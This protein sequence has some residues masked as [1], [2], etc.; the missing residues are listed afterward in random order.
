[1]PDSSLETPHDSFRP[2]ALAVILVAF[3]ISRMAALDAGVFIHVRADFIQLVDFPLLSSHLLQSIF[4][5]HS[6][7]PLLNLLLGIALKLFPKDYPIFFAFLFWLIGLFLALTLYNLM[8]ALGVPW[9]LS[10][11]LTLLFEIGPATILFE[12]LYYE[13]YPVAL[14]L[15][16]AAYSL[17]RFLRT[18]SRFHG[19]IFV[20]AL[21]LP[22][23]LNAS[24][25]VTWFLGIGAILFFLADARIKTLLPAG[26]AMLAVILALYVK[27]LIVFGTFTTSSSFG[28]A[29]TELTTRQLRA[30]EINDLVKRHILSSYALMLPFPE[31]SP[32]APPTG[33]PVLDETV[34]SRD[35]ASRPNS[36]SIEYLELTRADVHDALW[37]IV[38][39]PGAFARGEWRGIKNY[40]DPASINLNYLQREKIERWSELYEDFLYP[41]GLPTFAVDSLLDTQ[42]RTAPATGPPSTVLMIALPALVLFGIIK[43]FNSWKATHLRDADGVTMLYIVLAILYTTP[44]GALVTLNENNRYRYVLDPLYVVL[45]GLLITQIRT[46]VAGKIHVISSR[47][48]ARKSVNST[49]SPASAAEFL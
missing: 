16:Y 6:Q 32:S 38:H 47:N 29:I 11:T 39:R 42:V 33:V 30:G 3:A 19:T 24:F 28:I 46:A 48:F 23:F 2:I 44:F 34:Y 15:C 35:G 14:L 9:W 21:G 25:Q 13:T 22:V 45:L 43:V 5:L 27:N 40:F 37:V 31:L 26:L 10:L 12:N 20:I 41:P 8:T 49:D 17:N 18:G 1:M 7:P 4:Y 36:N